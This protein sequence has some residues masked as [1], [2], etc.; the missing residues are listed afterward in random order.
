MRL[1]MI[2]NRFIY[3]ISI[4]YVINKS[5]SASMNFLIILFIFLNREMALSCPRQS[6]FNKQES[7][8][9]I[10]KISTFKF[11]TFFIFLNVFDKICTTEI[12]L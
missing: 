2:E 7:I 3:L 6:K 10:L 4:D 9:L 12:V 1:I 5:F 8:L 11:Y